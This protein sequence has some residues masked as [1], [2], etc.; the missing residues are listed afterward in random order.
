MITT[1]LENMASPFEIHFDDI[2]YCPRCGS[3]LMPN[4]R[5]DNTFVETPHIRNIDSYKTFIQ[6]AFENNIV[7]LELGVGFNTPVIIR[8]PFETITLQYQYAKLIRVN[9]AENIVSEKINDK[10][11]FIQEDIGKAL[12]DIMNI[13]KRENMGN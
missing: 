7:L 2:P 3:Y 13:M 4:L 1:M 9:I 10:S 8:Y 6:N 11:I 5:C 12:S